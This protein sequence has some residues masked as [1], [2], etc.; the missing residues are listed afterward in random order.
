MSG[1][2]GLLG[3]LITDQQQR[4]A[5][6]IAVAPV[7]AGET[8]Y[9][10]TRVALDADGRAVAV[11]ENAIG[12][13][14]PFLTGRVRTGQTVWLFLMPGSV[15]VI[16]HEWIH[17]AFAEQSIK[18]IPM[19]VQAERWMRNFAE[20]VGLSYGIVLQAADEWIDSDGDVR[21]VQQGSEAA[22]NAMW[23]ASKSAFWTNY[24]VIRGRPVPEH[25]RENCFCCTC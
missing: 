11:D 2:Q 7:I 15:T 21:Y 16:R 17:P 13:I 9:P 3:K 23:G 12:I 19:R 10:G 6:H 25:L 24:E 5:I 20:E 18:S 4:D 22:R 14:D 8:L 1:V